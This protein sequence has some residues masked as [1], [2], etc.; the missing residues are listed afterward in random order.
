MKEISRLPPKESLA[1]PAAA[2]VGKNSDGTRG[3]PNSRAHADPVCLEMREHAHC[4]VSSY[5]RTADEGKK[6]RAETSKKR[7]VRV[8]HKRAA[9]IQRDACL[10]R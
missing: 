3:K 7:E 2:C 4:C 6:R 10:P 5:C 9:M 8:K 1:S